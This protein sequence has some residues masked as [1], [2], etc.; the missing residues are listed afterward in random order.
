MRMS[1]L[2]PAPFGPRMI[3]RGPAS[4]IERDP[5]DDR[6][7]AGTNRPREPQRQEDDGARIVRHP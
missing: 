7:P 3:V 1:T 2:L 4:S 5:I 6:P